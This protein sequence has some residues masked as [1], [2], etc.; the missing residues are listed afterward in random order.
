MTYQKDTQTVLYRSKMNPNT[1]EEAEVRRWR[2][3]NSIYWYTLHGKED[4]TP[5]HP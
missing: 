5:G 3:M 4:G 1:V 2:Y